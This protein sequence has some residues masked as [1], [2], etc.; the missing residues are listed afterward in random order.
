[1]PTTLMGTGF[2]LLG[3]AAVAANESSFDPITISILTLVGTL[4]SSWG[5]IKATVSSLQRELQNLRHDY[6]NTNQWMQ[7]M[8]SEALERISRIEGKLDK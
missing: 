2:A 4:A 1:M 7:P 3:T 8:L 5:I 6:R